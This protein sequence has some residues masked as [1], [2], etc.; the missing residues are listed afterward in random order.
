MH[1]KMD[2]SNSGERQ[3]KLPF[4]S[5]NGSSIK[6]APQNNVID[7][8][9]KAQEKIDIKLKNDRRMSI[10]KLLNYAEKLNW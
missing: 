2:N 3:L 9:S 1:R 8:S 4:E 6:A 7:F 10:S 5:N